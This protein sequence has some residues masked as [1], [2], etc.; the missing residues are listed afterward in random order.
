MAKAVTG[1]KNNKNNKRVTVYAKGRGY[2]S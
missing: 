1:H 2:S